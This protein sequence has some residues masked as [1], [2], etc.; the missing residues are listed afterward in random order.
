M[1]AGSW[2]V[3]VIAVQML[4]NFRVV[5]RRRSCY[6]VQIR[7]RTDSQ[8]AHFSTLMKNSLILVEMKTASLFLWNPYYYEY[9]RNTFCSYES[10][11]GWD[12]WEDIYFTLSE[13]GFVVSQ[14]SCSAQC[15][16]RR[17]YVAIQGVRLRSDLL[18][19]CVPMKRGGGQNSR[20]TFSKLHGKL[21][22]YHIQINLLF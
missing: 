16:C 2:E 6:T 8:A 17:F 19:L 21:H 14:E 13:C 7:R 10:F 9:G 15:Q 1:D 18:E 5:T 22:G 12:V 3:S 4:Q 11:S 20:S